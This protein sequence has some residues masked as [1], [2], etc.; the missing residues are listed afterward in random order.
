MMNAWPLDV[1]RGAIP[2]VALQHGSSEVHLSSQAVS[3]TV[4]QI[5]TG[6]MNGHL[7][8]VHRRTHRGDHCLDEHTH[9]IDARMYRTVNNSVSTE[10]YCLYHNSEI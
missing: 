8:T 10:L 5:P 7:P 4:N 6:V 2:N 9:I 3:H 1:L